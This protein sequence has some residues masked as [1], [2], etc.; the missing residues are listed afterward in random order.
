MK[1]LLEGL[2]L[3][4]MM[5]PDFNRLLK[6]DAFDELG[7]TLA[8]TSYSMF[9]KLMEAGFTED[10]AMKVLLSFGSKK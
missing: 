10:Q 8:K 9:C 7:E 1:E 2:E 6:S 3:V 4:R 5:L